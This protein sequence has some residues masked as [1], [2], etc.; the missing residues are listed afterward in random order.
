MERGSYAKGL[1]KREEILDA[2]LDLIAEQGY[3]AVTI[4]GVADQARLSKAGV[5]HHFAS[6]DE[7][8]TALLTRR[9]EPGLAATREAM[10]EG[11][12]DA[13]RASIAGASAT[14]ALTELYVR[15]S[16]EASDPANVA[17]PFFAE[18]YERLAGE[19]VDDVV[20]LQAVGQAP[21]GV[22]PSVLA[23]LVGAVVDGLQLRLLYE[24]EIEVG[25]VVDALH[26][27]FELA[28]AGEGD[29]SAAP[30]VGSSME[31]GEPA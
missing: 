25:A 10:P 8:L 1:A 14:P 11:L 3:G 24:P 17:H 22:D 2:T 21:T 28:A 6:K 23:V 13:M 12:F 31:P 26:A 20:R 5:A 7:L 9:D 15:L 18:R 19:G 4:R 16:A 27:L 30:S 29:P